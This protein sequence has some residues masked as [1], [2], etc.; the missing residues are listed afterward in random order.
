VGLLKETVHSRNSKT[1]SVLSHPTKL[2]LHPR[3]RILGLGP[4]LIDRTPEQKL[5][6]ASLAVCAHFHFRRSGR[7]R[8]AEETG[9]TLSA[10][11]SYYWIIRRSRN[12]TERTVYIHQT[13]P[14][15]LLEYMVGSHSPQRPAL[16]FQVE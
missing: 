9:A 12:G 4:G 7:E 13:R 14:R 15:G 11:Y 6:Q 1:N 10:R 2:G 3:S 8:A 16:Y 5:E